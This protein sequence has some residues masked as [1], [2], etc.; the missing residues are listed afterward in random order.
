MSLL[1]ALAFLILAAGPAPG[2]GLD[3]FDNKEEQRKLNDARQEL[4]EL[5]RRIARKDIPPIEFEFNKAVLKE[6]SKDTLDLV[7]DLLLRYPNFK[8]FIAGHTCDIGGD[9]YNE[10]LSQKRAEAVKDYLVSVGVMGEFIKAKG[11]G[12]SKPIADNDTEEGR[13]QNRRVE[14]YLTTRWWHSVY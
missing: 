10:W 4:K 1:R 7:A 11:Y 3:V 14:F 8:L 2:M 9:R 13:S 12:E 5:E 6:K